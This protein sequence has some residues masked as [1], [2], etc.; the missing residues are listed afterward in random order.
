MKKALSIAVA[1]F[2]FGSSVVTAGERLSNDE[3][4]SFYTDKTVTTVH[5]KL[6]PGK[7][8]YGADGSI[9]SKSD[10]GDERI[11]KWW[12]DEGSNK[13]CVRWDNKNKDFCH[14]TEKNS[15]G[16]HTL[17]HGKNGK[18]IVELK[19]AQDGNSL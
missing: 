7:T 3:L 2:I 6:G 9:H 5:F 8:Y 1:S 12:I 11:G 10:S 15:D 14:Y 19:S 17:I 18:K 16:T 4:K 13:R